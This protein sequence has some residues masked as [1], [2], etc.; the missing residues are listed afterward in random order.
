MTEG[1]F[2]A[3]WLHRAMFVGLALVLLFLRLLPVSG[4]AGSF[5]GPDI[6]LCLIFCWTIRRPDYLPILLVAAVVLAEDMIIMRPPGLWTAIVVGATEFIRARTALTR[7][8]SFGVEWLLVGA[9]MFG[10]FLINR[11]VLGLAFVPQ[12]GFGFAM[13]QVIWSAICYP[14][15]VG[16]SWLALDIRKPA[17]GEVDG[18]GRRL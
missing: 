1:L 9:V 13:V 11:L 15:V 12:P 14:A 18:K 17:M 3:L 10:M 6:L 16:I 7:E 4:E 8:V 2:S 5:P